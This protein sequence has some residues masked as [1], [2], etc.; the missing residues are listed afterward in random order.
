VAAARAAFD[1]GE[2]PRMSGKQRGKVMMKLAELIEAN[3]DELAAIE[4]LDNGKPLAMSKVHRW[5][6]GCGGVWVGSACVCVQVGV[7]VW[8][9]QAEPHCSAAPSLH[10]LAI[11]AIDPPAGSA[12]TLVWKALPPPAACL[13]ACSSPTSRCLPITSATLRGGQTRFRARQS[14]ATAPLARWVGVGG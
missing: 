12:F 6:G 3:L 1:S 7:W 13:P 8:S 10:T 5:G 14:L 11:A 9:G 2:W 4:S